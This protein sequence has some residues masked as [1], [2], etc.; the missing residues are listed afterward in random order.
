MLNYTLGNW[1]VSDNYTDTVTATKSL[2]IPDLSYKVDY[3]KKED[4]PASASIVNTT[5][6][7]LSSAESIK[8][9]YSPV[10]NIYTNT[11]VDAAAFAP[12]KRGVQVMAEITENYTAINSVTGDEIILPC[13]GRVVLRFPSMSCVNDALIKD[14]LTRSVA[15][16]FNTGLTDASRVIEMAKGSL[17]PSGL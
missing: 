11:D 1:T 15:A 16:A 2:A 8:F 12:S 9:G 13:K 14:L 10:A 7:G 17:L 5:S 6:T 3:A 4:E